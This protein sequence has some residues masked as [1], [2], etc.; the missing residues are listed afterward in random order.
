MTERTTTPKISVI[1]PC[2]NVPERLISRVLASLQA[3]TFRDYE[4][5]IVDDGSEESFA[6]PLEALCRKT[7]NAH[8]IRTPNAGVSEARNTGLAHAG[9]EYIT[10]VDADDFVSPDFL[11]RAW[12]I[13]EESNAEIVIGGTFYSKNAD[14]YVFPARVGKPD[15]SVYV[16]EDVRRM[17]YRMMGPDCQ[18][19]FPGGIVNR[20]PVA[21]LVK[22]ALARKFR[23]DPSV[24]IAEDM[25]WNLQLLDCCRKLCIAPEVWYCYWQNPNSA[26]HRFSPSYVD[27]CRAH[28]DRIPSLIDWD[29]DREYY[30]YVNRIFEQLR[31]IWLF[32]LRFEK[33]KDRVSYRQ[34]V[35]N[36]YTGRPWTEAGAA[37]Y[38]RLA[39]GQKKFASVLYCLHCYFFFIAL[40]ERFRKEKA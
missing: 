23:F 26:V 37:R 39:K 14:D 1:I 15:Y 31:M 8:C 29:E 21:R 22:T 35:H 5:I 16:G 20:G 10:F 7:E 27:D 25:V 32:Y 24:H 17:R 12:A 19:R 3:Q 4:L 11:E 9:G 13:R 33:Q 2:Y 30:S 18:I 6:S 38:R 36:L 40:R 28:L 34:A